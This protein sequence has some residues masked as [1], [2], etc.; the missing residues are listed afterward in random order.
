MQKKILISGLVQGIG[1]RFFI[2]D[3]AME[4][5]V[6]GWTRNTQDNKVEALFQGDEKTVLKLIDLCKTGPGM[7]KVKKVEEFKSSEPKYQDF[8]IRK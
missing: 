1:F 8:I 6:T 4:L 5:G 3:R 7:A 2:L